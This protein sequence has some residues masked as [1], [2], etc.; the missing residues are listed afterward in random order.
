MG[1]YIYNKVSEELVEKFKKIVLGKVYIKD[2][3]NKDFF[4]D[5]MFIYGEGE[6]EV[7]ID[8]IIIEVILEIM[9]LCYENNIFVILRGVGIGLIGVVVVIIGGVMLNMIKMNKILVYDYENFVVRVE[10]G[11][12]LN[13][14]VEDVLK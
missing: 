4:Y 8:V 10:L 1:N 14:L 6:L 5:E 3:I 13:E 9:K 12:L 11:V 7:V 2:E